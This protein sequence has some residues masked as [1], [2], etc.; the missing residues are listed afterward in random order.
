MSYGIVLVEE[1][2]KSLAGIQ[3]LQVVAAAR[4]IL[5][6]QMS[7]TPYATCYSRVRE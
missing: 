3:S 7:Q 2:V 1:L 5:Y 6:R 4:D